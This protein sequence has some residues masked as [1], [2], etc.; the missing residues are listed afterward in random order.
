MAKH[1]EL[2]KWG[3]DVATEYLIA[4]GYAI[5]E[6]NWRCGNLEIDIIAYHN[7][8]IVFVEVKTRHDPESRPEEAVDRRRMSRMVR[9]ADA[10]IQAKNIPHPVQYDVI[11]ISGTPTDYKLIHFDDAFFPRMRT[12][13]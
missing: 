10:Y 9:A 5:A 4:K 2:G 7:S 1:N 11:A 13:R 12:H 6:R 8:R 3:E